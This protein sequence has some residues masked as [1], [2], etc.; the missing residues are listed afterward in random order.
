MVMMTLISLAV[1][2]TGTEPIFVHVEVVNSLPGGSDFY[3]LLKT[4]AN[5]LDPDQDQ[6][7]VGP[8]LDPNCLTL[9]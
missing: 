5:N 4:F 9:R 8:D 6:Q 3:P 7:K 1:C 2:S